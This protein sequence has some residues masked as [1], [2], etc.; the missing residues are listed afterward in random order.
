MARRIRLALSMLLL[1]PA[2]LVAQRP[3]MGGFGKGR[4]PGSLAREPG[5][6][7]PRQV[8]MINLLIEHR[9]EVAL[10][11]SQFVRVITIKRTLDSTNAPVMRKLDSVERLFRGGTP[12]FS[13]PSPARRDSLA[14]ARSM[15]REWTAIVHENNE[16][17]R[18]RAYLLLGELQ[19]SKAET[20]EAT[21]EKAI[22][23]AEAKKRPSRP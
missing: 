22:A 4:I 13:E 8:N 10:S 9:Q 2:A 21:A 5:I 6:V 11:D 12:I 20:I 17:A 23:D 7:V 19:R 15:V 18:D 3:G 14:E 1:A 16:S